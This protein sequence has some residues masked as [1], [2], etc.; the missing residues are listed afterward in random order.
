MQQVMFV[1]GRLYGA[2][3]TAVKLPSGVQAG[4]AWYAVDVVGRTSVHGRVSGQ[5]QFGVDKHALIMPTVGMT[6]SG[7]GVIGFTL[8]G[9]SFYPTAAFAGFTRRGPQAIRVASLGKAPE[10]GFTGYTAENPGTKSARWGDYGAAS[11]VGGD[12]WIANEYIGAPGCTLAQYEA[13]AF[14]CGGTRTALANWTT[15]ISLVRP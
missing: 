4:I 7:R 12:V 15:R 10:D 5:G 1:R 2:H 11:V 8:T 9:P 14:S 6:D 3:G 13:T